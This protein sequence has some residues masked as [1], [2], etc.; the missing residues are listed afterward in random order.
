MDVLPLAPET[1][2]AA[3]GGPNAGFESWVGE[4]HEMRH[5][6]AVSGYVGE[7][8]ASEAMTSSAWYLLH[9]RC[10]PV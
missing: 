9:L 5:N 10:E 2:D 4:V 1:L 7:G 8:V 3:G 6:L